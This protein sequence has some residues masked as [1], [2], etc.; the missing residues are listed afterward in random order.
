MRPL[1][2]FLVFFFL[3]NHLFSSTSFATAIS[4]EDWFTI[5][6]ENFHIHHTKPLEKYAHK[7]LNALES[8]LPYLEKD[9][10]WKLN[11]PVDIV[12]QDPTDS[13]NGL[14]LNFPSTIIELYSVP[15][16]L[17]ST[18]SHYHNWVDEIAI[19]ELTHIVANDTTRSA[20]SF[21]RT[22]FG[23]WV[24]PNG[25]QPVWLVEGL[26]VYQ[27]TKYSPMGRGRSPILEA[28]LREASRKNLL[29]DK[30]YI[31]I[32]RFN[33]G[34][35]WWPAGNM[36]YLLGYAIQ[37]YANTFSKNLPGQFSSRNA[38][39][40]VFMPNTVL[41]KIQE[42][43]WINRWN[44]LAD[45]L[46]KRYPQREEKPECVLTN[47]GRFTG[48]HSIAN[49]WIYFSEE[50]NDRGYWLSRIPL[51]QDCDIEKIE[52]LVQREYPSPIQVSASSD[53]KAVVY[54]EVERDQNRTLYNNLYLYDAENERSKKIENTERARDPAL[55]SDKS[56]VYFI[57]QNEDVTQS[58]VYHHFENNQ[59]TELFK[60]E[61]FARLS[62]LF[63]HSD[64]LYFSLHSNQGN[65]SLNYISTT[66]GAVTK[67]PL[68]NSL[69]LPR[70]PIATDQHLYFVA[71]NALNEQNAYQLEWKSGT[72]RQIY[73]ANSGY[74]E[75]VIPS[76]D[77]NLI[78]MRYSIN[79]FDLIK[80]AVQDEKITDQPIEDLHKF[81]SGEDKQ[82]IPITEAKIL[83][84]S[85]PYSVFS[86]PATSLW[87]QYW[88]PSL[89]GTTN[90]SLIGAATGGNDALFYHSYGLSAEYDTRARFPH[91]LVYYLNRTYPTSFYFEA[92]Q[93]NSYFSGSKSSNRYAIYQAE[94]NIPISDAF[95]TLGYAYQERSL[96]QRNANSSIAY[97]RILY[98]NANKTPSAMS[99]NQGSSIS[100]TTSA[101][102]SSGSE[103]LFY[104][105]KPKFSLF[106]RGIAPN[107][108][109]GLSL[110]AGIST[111]RFLASNY[112]LGG[113]ASD[114][115]TKNFIVR[116]YPVD[117]LLG[118]KIITSNFHYTLPLLTLYRGWS[119]NP[120]F[121]KKL[122]LRFSADIGTANFIANYIN[123][124]F[125]FYRTYSLAKKFLPGFGIDLVTE[126][127]A[128]YHI[129]LFVSL[130]FHYGMKKEFGGG[131]TAYLG[132][133]VGQF[134]SNHGPTENHSH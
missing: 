102:P 56:G 97:T 94:A 66:G 19:H 85:S 95:F 57:K 134:G 62:S 74:V 117:V 127:S 122:G 34:N 113:G 23:S 71:V 5:K 20:Y 98:S 106:F 48:G 91:Y 133:G 64:R 92:Q 15:F 68:P 32:D 29:N 31:S 28:L 11:T 49:G 105:V 21:L 2:Q 118:Q 108:S 26:A 81:L 6:S 30:S 132:F 42:S 58:I 130:G 93:T 65:E 60:S 35:E 84:D 80:T 87:P 109:V 100:L 25:L 45:I 22:I 107:H 27:E 7:V 14:A 59:Q 70:N 37:S 119:T 16:D 128:L 12:V 13:A 89:V 126:G 67:I 54:T 90:G 51:S 38:G 10:D 116:G 33:D 39:H 88:M 8:A 125:I 123:D 104:E 18:L 9:L 4:G 40:M 53:A 61:P 79:G 115:D 43:S 131:P 17:E 52:R 120:L 121:L 114:I 99:F 83:E 82:E 78:A 41:E 69:R 101:F 112:F 44:E 24:K 76:A 1:N 129:P 103:S 111:N 3:I 47:S 124:S 63:L 72:I 55:R 50:N 46:P 86:S 36:P 75:R 77:N 110:Q 96:F 73:R